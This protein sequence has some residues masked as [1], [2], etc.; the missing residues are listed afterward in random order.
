MI[1]FQIPYVAYFVI[2]SGFNPIIISTNK[3]LIIHYKFLLF[4]FLSNFLVSLVIL[5][6]DKILFNPV[7]FIHIRS[8]LGDYFQNQNKFCWVPSLL[9]FY[10]YSTRLLII[11]RIKEKKLQ[12]FNLKRK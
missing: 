12:Y 7:N 1:N 10:F 11:I 8:T 2:H 5:T 4:F 9:V 3:S 6:K